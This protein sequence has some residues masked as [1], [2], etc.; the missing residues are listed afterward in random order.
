MKPTIQPKG[1]DYWTKRIS[2]QEMPALCSTVRDLE[3]LAKDDVSSLALLGRSVMHDNALTSRILRVANSAI[4]NKGINQV[5]TVSRAAVV[6][7]FDTIRNI[8]ITAK[9][10]TSLLENKHLSEGVYQRLLKLMAQSFQ[11]AMLARMMMSD[12]GESLREEVFIASLLYRIGESAFWSMGGDITD[13]LDR[14][15]ALIDNKIDQNSAI[16]AE[17][18]TSFI[19]LTQGIARSWGLGDVLLKSL[20]QPDERMPEIR[21]IFLADKLAEIL[22]KNT[23]DPKEL[24]KRLTQAAEMLDVSIEEMTK[25]VIHCNEMTHKLAIEYGANAIVSYLPEP[26]RVAAS[27]ETPVAVAIVR[28]AD[29]G[30]QLSKL[31]QLTQYAVVKTDFNQIM[32][33]ALEGILTGVGVDR[34]GVLL[35]SPSRKLLQPRVMLGDDAEM[36][37]HG[38][39]IELNDSQ[40]VFSQ[41]IEQKRSIWVNAP[42]SQDCIVQV[43]DALVEKLSSF[44]FLIA[45]L[46]IGNKVLGLFYAD[47]HGTA[48]HFEPQDN[49]SFTHFC[50]LAN[51]CFAVS[52]S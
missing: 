25:K 24:Q 7:G 4:Y 14:K 32:Q 21:C 9:L 18:G 3:K 16:R 8:C 19:Q 50:Q 6:L 35:L 45:P 46:A 22:S 20:A 36:L 23:S 15:L 41:C 47:R 39:V 38:F 30:Y 29:Q 10:L 51:V 2:D 42:S 49:D 26:S 1:A 33:T 5:S 52:M 12:R 13:N 40:S 11:A 43:D 31:R 27:I 44:G 37:K 48:R 34:C 28:Q 17:L